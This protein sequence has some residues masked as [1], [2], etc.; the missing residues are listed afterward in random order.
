[1]QPSESAY[2]PLW[3]KLSPQFRSDAGQEPP[4]DQ[5]ANSAQ[6]EAS[7]AAGFPVEYCPNCAAKLMGRSCKL[8]CPRCGYFL[9]CSDYY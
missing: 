5:P 2:N 9:S 6:R 7:P 8:V 3:M 1:M 4:T